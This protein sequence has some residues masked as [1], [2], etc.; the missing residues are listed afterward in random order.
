M[1]EGTERS[2]GLCE[3]VKERMKDNGGEGC[4]VSG[5]PWAS[6]V[7]VQ[8][9]HHESYRLIIIIIRHRL[10]HR[11]NP[12]KISIRHWRKGCERV[13]AICFLRVAGRCWRAGAGAAGATV[14]GIPH[15]RRT[16]YQV[17]YTRKLPAPC[18]P[19]ARRLPSASRSEAQRWRW[20]RVPPKE[21]LN[22][23]NADSECQAH[24]CAFIDPNRCVYSREHEQQCPCKSAV[25]SRCARSGASCYCVT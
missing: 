14:A 2:K 3:T 8:P 18:P 15:I 11:V 10:N 9:R 17:R 23:A 6:H 13:P 5:A 16:L 22:T 1:S 12:L 7:Q 20:E 25:G 19:P 21:E 4:V 24:C